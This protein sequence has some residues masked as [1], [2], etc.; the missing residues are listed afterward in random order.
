MYNPYLRF[1]GKDEDKDPLVEGRQ[2]QVVSLIR[3]QF[4]KRFESSSMA[5][6]MSCR[7]LM[8]KLLAWIDVHANNNQEKNR[9]E[10]WKRRHSSLIEYI[11]DFQ[12][13]LFDEDEPEEDFIP[14]EFIDKA[15][16]NKL[17]KNQFDIGTILDDAYEDLDNLIEFLSETKKINPKKDDKLQCLIK[18]LKNDK[19]LKNKKILIFS[20]FKATARYISN[21]L[22]SNN[23]ES[24]E[25]IDSSTTEN[26]SNLIQRFSPYYNGASSEKLIS[27]NKKEIKILVSTDV[28]AEGLNLQDCTRLINYDL[29]WNP[30]RL[31]QRV[32]RIDRRLDND[33]EELI[34]SNHPEQIRGTIVYWNFLPPGELDIL[35]K[36]Y[37]K[38]SKKTLRISKVLGI[39]G[40][41]LLKP[42][43]DF[44]DLIDFDEQYEGKTSFDEELQ[45]EYQKLLSDNPSLKN[46]ILSYPNKMFSGKLSPQ[47]GITGLFLCFA[48]PTKRKKPE[49]E[50]IDSE[51]ELWSTKDGSIQWYF[52]TLNNEEISDDPIRIAELI[53]S[54]ETH[55]RRVKVDK[56]RLLDLRR[57]VEKHIK[58]DYLRRMNAPA[59]VKPE[60]R[61][62][63]EI[64]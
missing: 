45:L 36:L 54:N 61:S 11:A 34:K 37:K 56:G 39:E 40:R 26:R 46:K 15:T 4:L 9:L 22:K 32:G 49:E 30:V 50:I 58:N 48:L 20:E 59:G 27:E 12:K 19:K 24:V 8:Y 16:D 38:V 7:V 44:D 10:R 41:K 63:M 18:L 42:D 6:E 3:L 47:N 13:D 33:T 2:K 14:Q 64:N 60:L 28:L 43:D 35:L 21:Q 29:H 23:F 55:N 52:I 25:V 53:R 57:K 5:F 1:I 17:D 51:K 62:W 31:M